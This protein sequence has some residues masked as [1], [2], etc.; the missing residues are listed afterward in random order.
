MAANSPA[1]LTV[2]RREAPLIVSFPHAGID[3]PPEIEGRCVSP[4][5]ARKDA[6][7]WIDQLYDF[8][9]GMGA[10]T[11]HTAISR[12][13]IDV[14]RD[15]SG[16]SLYPGQNTTELVPTTT[17]DGEPL[18]RAGHAPHGSEIAER[19]RVYFEPYHAALAA[20]VA[21]LR[22]GHPRIV[23]YD[24]HS[25]RSIVPRLFPGELPVMNIGTNSGTACDMDLAEPITA[26]AAA[27]RFSAVVDGRF[28]G[29]YITRRYGMPER[30]VHTVQMELACRGY[31][32]EPVGPVDERSW[33]VPYDPAYAGEI[34]SVLA[35]I[36]EACLV[37]AGEGNAREP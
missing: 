35:S 9:A 6:D 1:W 30:G 20:E 33:P 11:I 13:V 31:L 25:I 36:L 12:T 14:N 7:W 10:T 17:F 2:E 8:V 28:K 37:F 32:R 18:W 5:L 27:S 21:R 3:I 15:P 26:I 24:C 23:L 19:R 16:A 22:S 4:W 34:R 29:G